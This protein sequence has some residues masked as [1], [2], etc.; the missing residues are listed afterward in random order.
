MSG[1]VLAVFIIFVFVIA[2]A[3]PIIFA[4]KEHNY[5]DKN[6]RTGTAEIIG[7]DSESSASKIIFTVK[8]LDDQEHYE[9]H[10]N[11]KGIYNVKTFKGT[12]DNKHPIFKIGDIVQVEYAQKKVLGVKFYDV[13]LKDDE[14][15]SGYHNN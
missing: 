3:I 5:F 13:R 12:L 10:A 4:K 2:I 8:G 6:K 14:Y 11:L 9:Y 1:A 7:Y 15:N